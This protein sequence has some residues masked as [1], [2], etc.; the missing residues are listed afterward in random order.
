MLPK[1]DYDRKQIPIYGGFLA[2]FPDAIVAVAKLSKRGNDQHNPGKPMFW[3]R[4]KSKDERESMTRH[5]LA[6][7]AATSVDE[8]LEEAT[9]VAWRA[10]ANLQKLC[11]K[12]KTQNP[13]NG[14]RE[15]DQWP[16]QIDK[17]GYPVDKSNVVLDDNTILYTYTSAH[18]RRWS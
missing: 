5:L 8:E 4:S 3:D 12:L 7:A 9:A 10:M 13:K 1:D 14:N 18:S 11:E 16:T 2:Y 15:T 17:H 6:L